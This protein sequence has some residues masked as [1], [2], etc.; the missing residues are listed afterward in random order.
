MGCEVGKEEQEVVLT[1]RL[2]LEW[3]ILTSVRDV[4]SG[5]SF[6]DLFLTDAN[7]ELNK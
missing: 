3:S 5:L 6:H 2:L 1:L 7:E 4:F